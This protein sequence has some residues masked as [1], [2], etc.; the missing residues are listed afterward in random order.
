MAVLELLPVFSEFAVTVIVLLLDPEV[1]DT[2]NQLASSLILH[3]TF[4]VIPKVPE[5]PEPE[6]SDTLEGDTVR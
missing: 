5:D 1:G 3:D 2:V 4:D 6:P